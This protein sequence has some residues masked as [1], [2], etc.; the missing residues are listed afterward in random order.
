MERLLFILSIAA[1][2]YLILPLAG[3]FRVRRRWRNFRDALY[4]SMEMPI[5]SYGD[6]RER[7]SGSYRF[8]GRIE[9][10]QGENQLWL[11]EGGLSLLVDLTGVEVYTL[12]AVRTPPE[13]GRVE[14][15]ELTIA[16][17][18]PTAMAS[19]RLAA[20][21]LGTKMMVAGD[22][23]FSEG[24]GRL[25]STA[26]R[27]LLCLIYDGEAETILR[28]AIWSGR[29]RNEYWN[30][31]TP[32]SL[33]L[34]SFTLFILAYVFLRTPR[35]LPFAHIALTLSLI[36][37][38]PLLPPGILFFSLY[39]RIW[40]SGRYL[41]AERDL[42]ALPA[43]RFPEKFDLKRGGAVRLPDGS[44]Y[45]AEVFLSCE[46]ALS[47]CR[48][49]KIRTSVGLIDRDFHDRVFY[50]FGCRTG[51]RKGGKDPFAE[52]VIIPGEPRELSRRCGRDAR[53]REILAGLL[54]LLGIAVNGSLIFVLLWSLLI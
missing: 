36:P 30:P 12:P 33:T 49:G 38:A 5:L 27:A 14:D 28:R 44:D 4:A 26:D 23:C 19:R 45:S 1:L 6:L 32:L 7:Q 40:R 25:H 8:F 51:H 18:T 3:A 42:I 41:R 21:P 35:L 46:E 39:R 34:A 31:L 22:L 43:N 37:P 20:L 52:A 54:F 29:Q 11:R 9:A 17:G 13:E 2:G 24:R 53:R 10:S 47:A 50:A 15:N 48:D 16:E